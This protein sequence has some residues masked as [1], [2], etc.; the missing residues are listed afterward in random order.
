MEKLLLRFVFFWL[1]SYNLGLLQVGQAGSVAQS[2]G[3]EACSLVA[4]HLDGL[5]ECS[6]FK[7]VLWL[8]R[9]SHHK[10]GRGDGVQGEGS[11]GWSNV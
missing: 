9:V 7:V 8:N 6:W 3:V 10:L 1:I 11:K 5:A 2:R 4:V